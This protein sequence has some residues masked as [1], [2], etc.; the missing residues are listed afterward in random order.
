MA[1]KIIIVSAPSGCGKST[2]INALMDRGIINAQFSVSATNRPPRTGEVDGINYHF[3]TD[4]QFHDAIAAG[5]FIEFEEVYPGRYYGTL[6]K[7]VEQRM[8]DGKNVILDIDVCGG[9]NVKKMFGN[10]ALALFIFPPSVEELRRRLKSRGTDDEAEIN[11]RIS[12]AE[13]E[14]GFSKEYDK[15]V[16]ND[17][18]EKAIEETGCLINDFT[19][20]SG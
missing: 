15:T 16:I 4:E 9:V 10:E 19:G 20:Y 2:I 1:G 3:L 14:L 8:T 5:D 7:E 6:R 18:L 12:R 17:D 11:R 13:Y